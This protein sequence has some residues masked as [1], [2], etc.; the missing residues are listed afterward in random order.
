MRSSRE[1]ESISDNRDRLGEGP[2][3]DSDAGRLLWADI[4]RECVLEARLDTEGDWT[5]RRTWPMPGPVSAVV[6]RARGGLLAL[7]GTSVLAVS[8]NGR[9]EEFASIDALVAG[10]DPALVRFNDAKCDLAGRLFAGWIVLDR[11]RPGGLVRIDPDAGVTPVLPEVHGANGMGWS[12]DSR[13]FYLVDTARRRVNVFE[14][15]ALAGEVAEPRELIALPPGP[16]VP[17]GLA[18][19]DEG[20]LWLA[21]PYEGRVIRYHPSG[22]PIDEIRTPTMMPLS[23]AFG[24]DERDRMFITSGFSLP[25]DDLGIAAADPLAGTLLHCRVEVPGPVGTPFAG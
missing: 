18:V 22:D 11:S 3:Y 25:D 23:C 9:C 13:S 6:H 5:V 20:C 1:F 12:P 7:V 8:E 14:F 15:D 10:I 21:V 17:D 19:D 4:G 2:V 16:G 24:G